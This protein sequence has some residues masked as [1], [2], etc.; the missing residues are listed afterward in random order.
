MWQASTTAKG[1]CVKMP[2]YMF[3]VNAAPAPLTPARYP[4]NLRAMSGCAICGKPVVQGPDVLPDGR[5]VHTPCR[6]ANGPGLAKGGSQDEGPRSDTRIRIQRPR[7]K[8]G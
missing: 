7:R 8:T 3:S 1:T 2:E 4:L 5:L 6:D